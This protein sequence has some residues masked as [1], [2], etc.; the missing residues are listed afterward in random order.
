MK[1]G[2]FSDT[3]LDSDIGIS[4]KILKVIEENDFNVLNLEAPFIN[5][6]CK[7]I[8]KRIN[9]YNHTNETAFLEKNKFKYVNLANNHIFDFGI[10]GFKFTKEILN[11][12]NIETFGAGLNY[13]DAIKPVIF[14]F[15]GKKIGIWGFSDK[16]SF[17]KESSKNNYGVAPINNELFN[18]IKETFSNIDIRIA[19]I[20]AGVEYEEYPEPYYKDLYNYLAKNDYFNIIIGNHSH[21]IQ[22]F[23]SVS[24]NY[25]FYSLGNFIF[26]Q[27]Y[28][29]NIK[30]SH[31]DISNIGYF[32]N[33]SINQNID[34]EIVPY[35]VENNGT[36]IRELSKT[37]QNK[38]DLNK[39]NNPL[40]FDSYN[41]RKFYK[42][43]RNR[44]YIPLLSKSRFINTIK[45]NFFSIVERSVY[46]IIKKLGLLSIIKKN[47]SKNIKK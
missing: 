9:L 22:G 20:H 11:N 2:F 36:F 43:Y 18:R 42:K 19:Y 29:G 13:D 39:K 10:C 40:E 38:L 24:D 14:T 1:I 4:S 16:F 28:Y 37:E 30:L 23:Q 6:R 25:I 3:V 41:Y 26:P 15:S 27:K 31:Y 8:K 47:I 34:F 33:I 44:K 32:V 35:R 21:S 17:S 45:F 7:K 46:I 5:E 12:C